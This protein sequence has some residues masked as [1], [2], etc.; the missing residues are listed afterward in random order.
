M[1]ISSFEHS[2]KVFWTLKLHYYMT[3]WLFTS[4]HERVSVLCV[5]I[6]KSSSLSFFLARHPVVTEISM[7]KNPIP[8]PLSKRGA[9]ATGASSLDFS[10][11]LLA[12]AVFPAW[13]LKLSAI[14]HHSVGMGRGREYSKMPCGRL[15]DTPY[16]WSPFAKGKALWHA[17]W[18]F[19]TCRRR[20]YHR[21]PQ[22]S[23]P[24]PV[25]ITAGGIL[26]G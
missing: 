24:L 21:N 17:D 12:A 14:D 18:A 22:V 25:S 9:L 10:Q 3:N 23:P 20:L 8:T 15:C 7:N 4:K 5:Q 6:W 16:L 13:C 26:A 11:G 1:K 19:W 2:L